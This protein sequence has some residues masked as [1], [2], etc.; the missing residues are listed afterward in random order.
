MKHF[1]GFVILNSALLL[2]GC[3]TLK[4]EDYGLRYVRIKGQNYYCAPREWVVPPVVPEEVADDPLF[5]L[6][7]QFLNLPDMNIVSDAHAQTREACITQAQWP[8]WLMMRSRW[9]RDWAVTPGTAE[10]LAA[11]GAAGS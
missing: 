2:V 11:R 5:P 1:T 6:Y 10:E 4:P 8:Q 9:N 7:R 3:A